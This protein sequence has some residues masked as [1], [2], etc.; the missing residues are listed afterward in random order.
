MSGIAAGDRPLQRRTV[1]AVRSWAAAGVSKTPT[2]ATAVLV[3]AVW[4]GQAAQTA[5]PARLPA[6][7]PL[8][9]EGQLVLAT[10]AE[11]GEYPA[12]VL[13]AIAEGRTQYNE[14]K[15]HIRAVPAK[16][17]DRLI[18]LPPECLTATAADIF[19]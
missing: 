13:H 8:R 3:R 7:V 5:G 9:T 10:E 11:H 1:E 2:M 19:G 6:G 14:I 16:T 18:E 15:D 17:L 4:G 12:A